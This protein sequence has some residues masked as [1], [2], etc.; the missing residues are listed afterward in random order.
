[1]RS[2]CLSGV[3]SDGGA[4]TVVPMSSV[5][6]FFPT[7]KGWGLSR[8]DTGKRV[9]PYKQEVTTGED[10]WVWSLTHDQYREGRFRRK[11]VIKS[12]QA[13]YLSP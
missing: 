5:I 9:L 12:G 2:I 10:T 7:V 1:M 11:G 6:L 13:D 4:L 3:V 8:R